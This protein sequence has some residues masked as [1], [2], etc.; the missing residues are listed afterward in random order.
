[1]KNDYKQLTFA[2]IRIAA[3]LGVVLIFAAFLGLEGWA[4]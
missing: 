4:L 3:T 1:M 2:V